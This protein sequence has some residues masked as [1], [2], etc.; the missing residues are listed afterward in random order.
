MIILFEREKMITEKNK[1]QDNTT[2]H[3]IK[4][5]A[6]F[7]VVSLHIWLPGKVGAVYQIIARFAVPMFF[8]ISGFYS[9]NISK[10]KIKQRIK[11]MGKL[12]LLSTFFYIIIFVYILWQKRDLHLF[13]QNFNFT[14]IVRFVIFNRISDLIGSMATPLWYLY[15]MLYIYTYFS[16]KKLLLTKQ[17]ITLLIILSIIIEFMTNDSI[18]YRNFLFMGMPFFGIG[19][20]FSKMKDQITHYRKLDKLLILGLVLSSILLVLEYYILGNT[21]ELYIS[22]ILIAIILM[23]FAIK[24]PNA[25]NIGMLNDIGKNYTTFIYIT[26]EFIIF[27]FITFIS[28]NL[29]LKFGT[30][31]V[32]FISY[33]LGILFQFAKRY[34]IG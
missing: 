14:N 5:L 9:Y 29:I 21:F 31:F 11:K 6:C 20:L 32:F 18:F 3:A 15:A 13:I 4:V 17:S 34:K 28:N 30:I 1:M 7:S 24:K 23:L 22:S 33:S 2:L 19:T 12:I 16:K 26:H 10:E 25:I 8:L 27:I